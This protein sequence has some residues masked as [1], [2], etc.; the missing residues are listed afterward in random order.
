MGIAL[1]HDLK[2]GEILKE[3]VIVDKEVLIPAGTSLKQEYISLMETLGIEAVVVID[4]SGVEE[5]SF[6]QKE[7]EEFVEQVRKILEKHIF[8][9]KDSLKE[10]APLAENIIQKIAILDEGEAYDYKVRNTD[11]YEHTV[12]TTAL[13]I[14]LAKEL[15]LSSKIQ[16]E[17]AI[18]CLLHDIGLR[19]VTVDYVNRSL[20]ERSDTEL[21]EFKKHT[22]LGYTA[23]E[24]EK[25]IPNQSKMMVL[26]HHER[27]NGSG[28]PL[29]QK[30]KEIGCKIIQVCD[31]FDCMVS[32]MECKRCSLEEALTYIEEQSGILFEKEIVD[33]L[34]KIIKKRK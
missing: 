10:L 7:K 13:S 12:M 3:P 2:G 9:K 5:N 4:P 27:K 26:S 21:F 25:W 31:T 1:L 24:S 11:L 17:I 29:K 15:K 14:L 33:I 20:E 19:Y 22:V 6:F 8:G 18:G 28:Y 34:L 30:N 23:L 16:L 32:G